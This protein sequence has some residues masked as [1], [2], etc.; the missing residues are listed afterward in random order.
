MSFLRFTR[1]FACQGI[2]RI[3]PSKNFLTLSARPYR[4]HPRLNRPVTHARI[5][6]LHTSKPLSSSRRFI[7][8][9]PDPERPLDITRWDLGTR[10]VALAVVG[11]TTYY[12]YQ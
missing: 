11:G 4:V 7:R 10:L 6:S 3:T 12:V 9:P 1:Q 2:D 5:Q 8:F